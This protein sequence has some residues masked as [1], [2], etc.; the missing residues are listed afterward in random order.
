M[1]REISILWCKPARSR[2]KRAIHSAS[3][4]FLQSTFTCAHKAKCTCHVLWKTNNLLKKNREFARKSWDWLAGC[5]RGVADRAIIRTSLC[6]FQQF[7]R[8]QRAAS[9]SSNN[10]WSAQRGDFQP[11]LRAIISLAQTIASPASH[12]TGKSVLLFCPR[13]VIT[14][15]R[16]SLSTQVISFYLLATDKHRN[17][18]N[19]QTPMHAAQTAAV[20]RCDCNHWL[21]SVKK[22]NIKKK[23]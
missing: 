4:F 6:N 21:R 20:R 23:F 5:V 9:N 7:S 16:P 10:M 14:R 8:T 12:E 13:P 18:R 19:I 1:R 3:G 15:F 22:R 2:K 11:Q 17:R